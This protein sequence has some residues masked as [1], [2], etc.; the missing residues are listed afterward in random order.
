MKHKGAPIHS[1]EAQIYLASLRAKKD[2]FEKFLNDNK[3]GYDK[4]DVYATPR[5]LAVIVSGLVEK[6][7]DEEKLIKGPIAKV[8]YDDNGALTQAGIGF[9]RKNNI[10][11]ED[12]FNQDGYVYARVVVKGKSIKELLQDNVSKIVLKLQG[13]HFMRWGYNEEKFSRPIRWIVSVLDGD[14]VKVKI[15]DKESSNQS[16]GHRFDNKDIVINNPDEYIEKMR[17]AHVIVNQDERRQLIIDLAKAEA[18][19]LGAV[20]YYTDDLLEE[21]PLD[22]ES[23]EENE[24]ANN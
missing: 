17:D 21:V 13:S 6:S 9:A 23:S 15:I 7:S 16:R 2:G 14:E 12:L 3:V 22:D 20:P 18:D 8:A 1:I 4:V 5:R 24:Q 19:K 11:P 10:N